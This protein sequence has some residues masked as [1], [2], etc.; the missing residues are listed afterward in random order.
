MNDK[1]KCFGPI[2]SR[3]HNI[4]CKLE[5]IFPPAFFNVMVHLA[6]HLPYKIKVASLV[7][8]SWMYPIKMSLCTLK[9][10]VH[11]KAHIEGFIA[12]G[13]LMNELETFV[14]GI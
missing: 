2:A 14:R 12:E 4:L 11:N 8:Y 5:R 6:I 9:H 13:Y 3:Y 1:G 7:S 10:Y